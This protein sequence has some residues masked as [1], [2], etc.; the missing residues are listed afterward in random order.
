MAKHDAP[1][2][3]DETSKINIRHLRYA[4]LAADHGSFRSAADATLTR[5]STF[6]RNI[7]QLEHTIGMNIFERSSRGVRLSANGKSFLRDAR[8]I[9]EQL[10]SLTATSRMAGR[11]DIGSLVVGFYTSLSCGNLRAAIVEYAQH[12]PK[13]EIL[14]LEDSRTRLAAA[15]RSKSI[16][17]AIVTGENSLL[18]S[19]SRLLWSERILAVLPEKH[20]L[21]TKEGSLFWT[22]LR[23]EPL[24]LSRR[25][26][27]PAIHD[28][29]VAKL[30]TP[31]D[32]PKIVWHDVGCES[33]E[34]LIGAS[35]GLGLILEASLAA[36]PAGVVYREIRDGT[37]SARIGLCANWRADNENPALTNFLKLL[38]G[39]SPT[40]RVIS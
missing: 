5:E 28:Q 39:R 27:G 20:R 22:D 37:G 19:Q 10:D 8:S 34:H 33:I 7:R 13:V 15:V 40:P 38:E 4:L 35:F 23:E 6:S 18:G 21:A 2:K 12:F 36:S 16:D 9:V 14:M 29:L 1:N 30:M 31:E 11:G 3:I 17:V 24:L 26:P 25:D 32:R